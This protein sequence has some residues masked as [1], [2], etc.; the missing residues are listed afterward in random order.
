MVL[1]SH[2]KRSWF[3][4]VL[5]KSE[6][7]LRKAMAPNLCNFLQIWTRS[8]ALLVGRV[9]T[10]RSH[11]PSSCIAVIVITQTCYGNLQVALSL[12]RHPSGEDFCGQHELLLSNL[13]LRV[14]L[15]LVFDNR[16]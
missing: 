13:R 11:G 4:G 16:V 9:K 6:P 10:N 7:A 12:F 1:A 14:V 2:S 8:L 5:G 15:P 3:S